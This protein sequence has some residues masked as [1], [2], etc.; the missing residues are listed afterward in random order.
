MLDVHPPMPSVESPPDEC[1][2]ECYACGGNDITWYRGETD[3]LTG[4][5]VDWYECEECGAQRVSNP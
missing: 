1:L 5:R 2:D 3:Q 4:R